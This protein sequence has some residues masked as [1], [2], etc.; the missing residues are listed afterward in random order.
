[1]N[2]VGLIGWRGMVGSVL[3]SRMRAE[4]DFARIAPVFFSTSMA[5]APA[6][7]T[8]QAVARV[9]DANDTAELAR[10]DILISCQGGDYT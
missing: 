10:C 1:M 7:E 8:G 5:G 3:L 2:R 9:F 4:G 6:P